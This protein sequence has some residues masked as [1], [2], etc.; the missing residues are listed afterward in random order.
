MSYNTLVY[1]TLHQSASVE[2]PQSKPAKPKHVVFPAG[3]DRH[4]DWLVDFGD[5]LVF[6]SR[7]AT[8]SPNMVYAEGDAAPLLPDVHGD[9]AGT[10]ISGYIKGM[11]YGDSGLKKYAAV[12]V[13]SLPEQPTAAGIRPGAADTL[14]CAVPAEL[15]VYNTGHDLTGL[16]AL[17][18]YLCA[19]MAL[20]MPGAITL[21]GWPPFPYGQ[22]GHGP[23]PPKLVSEAMSVMGV[24]IDAF[25]KM[26]D[27]LFNLCDQTVPKLKMGGALR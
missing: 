8:G 25:D 4:S 22:M 19:R 24:S 7:D 20:L 21:A 6:Q 23:T 16:S 26:I 10:K 12:A 5:N 15:G 18:N 13:K 11:Q 9:N 1:N 2:S 3:V 17:W 27:V 14:A